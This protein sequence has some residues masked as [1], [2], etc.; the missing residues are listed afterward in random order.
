MSQKIKNFGEPAVPLIAPLSS[1]RSH[2][3]SA[4][5]FFWYRLRGLVLPSLFRSRLL[6]CESSAS[7]VIVRLQAESV[8]SR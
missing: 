1:W 7:A 6:R 3:E 2:I 8:V 5:S 4:M